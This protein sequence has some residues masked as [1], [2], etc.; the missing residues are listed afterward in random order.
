MGVSSW[1]RSV[2]LSTERVKNTVRLQPQSVRWCESMLASGF[3]H[4]GDERHK[5]HVFLGHRREG[6][7]R[8]PAQVS[9]LV[10]TTNR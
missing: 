7:F 6:L 1:S 4:R 8:P 10:G 3:Q 2:N 9:P 5:S